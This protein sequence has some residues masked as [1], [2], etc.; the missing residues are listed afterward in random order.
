MGNCFKCFRKDTLLA[1]VKKK[2]LQLRSYERI[3]MWVAN[4]KSIPPRRMLFD[5]VRDTMR[6][7]VCVSPPLVVSCCRIRIALCG[8]E[9]EIGTRAFRPRAEQLRKILPLF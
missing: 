7:G 4:C 6:I 5:G 2:L 9:S 3:M 8:L 1:S